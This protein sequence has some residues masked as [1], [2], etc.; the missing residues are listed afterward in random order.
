M[1]TPNPKRML[2]D[3]LASIAR[4]LGNPHRL[5]I[6][7]L[8]AQTGLSVEALTERTGL[9]FANVSQHLQQLKKAGLIAGRREGKRVIY[10]LDDGPIIEALAA[11]R[12]LAE[13]NV[14]RVGTLLET[15]YA[16]PGELEP[17][18]MD[19]LMERMRSDSV[20]LLDVRSPE[21]FAAGHLPGALNFAVDELAE[22]LAG[23]P[24]DREIVAY[25]RGPYCMLS[26]D[27][28]RALSGTGRKVRRLQVGLPEWRAAGLPVQS[29][30]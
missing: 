23:L 9:E 7:E 26:V 20:T 2:L 30:A 27:A 1:S 8:L 10:G 13:H 25:C 24:R 14:E 17:I 4:V 21:E 11:I 6:L 29:A 5:E 16:A 28:V 22:R 12:A 15:Y 3:E 18:G 19:E